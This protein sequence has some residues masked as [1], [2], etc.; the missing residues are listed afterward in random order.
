MMGSFNTLMP[1][2]LTC[3]RALP[4]RGAL[5]AAHPDLLPAARDMHLSSEVDRTR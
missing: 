1:M 2:T 4:G 5:D 3:P